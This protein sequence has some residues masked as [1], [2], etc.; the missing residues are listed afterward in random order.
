MDKYCK[1][2]PTKELGVGC[3]HPLGWVWV[4][5]DILFLTVMPGMATLAFFVSHRGY[6][7]Q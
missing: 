7:L 3:G 2:G 5:R 6:C 1:G 4:K